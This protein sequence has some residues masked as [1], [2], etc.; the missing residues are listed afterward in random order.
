M[1]S[2]LQSPDGE[3]L[4][5]GLG[6]LS[7]ALGAK[8]LAIP[9][10]VSRAIGIEP[11]I[12]VSTIMRA[13][14]AREIAAGLNVLMNPRRPLPLWIRVA[15]DLVDLG[16][17]G[18]A[19]T[20]RRS[21]PRLLGALAVVGGVTALDIIAAKKIQTAYEAANEPVIFSVTINKPP[22]EVYA[23]YRKFS[24]LPLF[25]DYLESV[26]ERSR[27][28]SHWVAKLPVGKIAWDAEIVQD[29]PGQLIAWQ[30]VDS[31]VRLSGRVTFTRTPGRNATE[32]RVAMALGFTGKHPSTLLAKL[33]T[34]P[35]IKGD[36]RRLKQVMETGEVLYSDAT[37]TLKP[38][39]A[40]PIDNV[41]RKPEF[42][43]AN[44]PTARKG[45]SP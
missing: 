10:L 27:T 30:S 3:K 14:G 28:R 43:V 45:V 15:G 40:Q 44:P 36:L 24:Q 2:D 17:L 9:R 12:G 20:R 38:R 13:M 39:P 16:L 11:G 29:V 34:K 25:M 21:T 32:V 1:T 4:A 22:D 23:F 7:L 42:F 33:F 19:F 5:K 35:Q 41:A 6:W 31:R 18:L 26:E 37:E 8:E